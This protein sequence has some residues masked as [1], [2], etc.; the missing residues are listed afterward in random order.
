MIDSLGFCRADTVAVTATEHLGHEGMRALAWDLEPHDVDL[1]VSPGMMDV[2]GQRLSMRPVAGL[3]L[4]HVEKPQYHGAQKFS[5]L[6]FD[7]IFAA[8]ALVLTSPVM[9]VAAL[10]IKLTSKGP[11]F[12]K[13]E[14]MGRDG[15]PFPM[16][17]FRRMVVDADKQV[18]ALMTA[19]EGAGVLF[20][21]REYPRVTRVGGVLRKYSLD[22][23]P[24]F[25][26]VLRREMSVVGPR[27]AAAPRSR[28]LRRHRPSPAAGEAG[29]HGPVA[30]EWE[31]RPLMGRDRAARSL[32]CGELVDDGRCPHH[33]QNGSGRGGG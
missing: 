4:I 27:P 31:I 25:L 9:I 17:N 7:T 13:S 23:L 33:R 5:K 32:V 29:H 1:V 24:Q 22:E 12:D 20:K 15:R 6:A 26:N 19:N 11:V 16:L 10:M 21:I 14:R 28:D 3:P 8:S 18:A 30:S 2:S